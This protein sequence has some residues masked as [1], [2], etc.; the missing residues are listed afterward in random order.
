MMKKSYCALIF[1]LLT[2]IMCLWGCSVKEDRDACPCDLILDL[3]EMDMDCYEDLRVFITDEFGPVYKSYSDFTDFWPEYGFSVPRSVLT[4]NVCSGEGGCFDDLK[5]VLIPYGEECPRIFMYSSAVDARCEAVRE[6]VNLN[7]NHCVVDLYLENDAADS[8]YELC[9]KGNVCGYGMNGQ[10]VQGE[11]SFRP[12]GNPDRGYRACLPRQSDTSLM[13]EIDDGS[14]VLKTF[15]L[16]E[17]IVAGGY[18]WTAPDLED[19]TVH[20]NWTLTSV[21]LTVSS[22]DWIY[23]CEIVI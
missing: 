7:K 13:L 5:G 2:S 20:I 10:P 8:R 17:Y 12:D 9:L 19:I 16:G 15:S 6:I 4:V 14:E 1:S 18:D 11:F 23:E 3:S 22:W 21:I